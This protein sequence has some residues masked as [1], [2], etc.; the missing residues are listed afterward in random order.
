MWEKVLSKEQR[1]VLKQAA[2]VLTKLEIRKFFAVSLIQVFLGLV[3]LV[4]IG[5]IGILGTLAITGISTN[6]PGDRVRSVLELLSIENS[7][8]QAQ[9]AVIGTIAAILMTFRTLFSIYIVRRVTFFLSRRGAVMSERLVSRLL[10]QEITSLQKRKQQE[11]L[12]GVTTG[13][14]AITMGILNTISILTADLVLLVVLGVGLFALDWVVALLSFSIIGGTAYILYRLLA[15]RSRE[16]GFR[17]AELSVSNNSRIL[18][19]L[20]SYRELVVRDRRG[21][22]SKQISDTRMQMANYGAEKAF[23]PNITKYVLEVVMIYAALIIAASQFLLKD[24]VQAIGMLAIFLA[25]STRMS[26]SLLRVQQSFLVMKGSIGAAMP[27]IEL[28]K[29]IQD[30]EPIG[31]SSR[32]TNFDH[33][34]IN[35]TV[36]V[37][38]LVYGYPDSQRNATEGISLVIEE[39]KYV[40]IVGPSGSGKTTLVDLILGI[41]R[42]SSGNVLI[43]GVPPWDLISTQPGLIAYVPQDV[44][45]IN[46]TVRDNIAMGYNSDQFSDADFEDAIKLSQLTHLIDSLPDG[47]DSVLA[48]KGSN[49]SGGQRQRIG[50]ARALFTKPKILIL[51]EATSSLDSSIE[52]GISDSLHSLRGEIT[53]IVIAHR[54]SSIMK[55]DEIIYIESGKILASGD[56]DQ[57]RKLVP[58]FDMHAR[59]MGIV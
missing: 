14:D 55:A 59:L 38:G 41:L 5:L 39:G 54:L 33:S 44:M 16:I 2:N 1:E 22:Y 47:L 21:Y 10:N 48:D 13:V 32:I 58:D 34:N 57:L 7:T 40:A 20:N 36:E 18:E 26:P 43:G 45:I 50:I 25:A 30:T 49:L 52:A 6:T 3:D 19:V 29:S 12:Y 24:A 56:F 4:A 11:I 17:Q 46:G 27:T 31:E 42:P 15:V 8:L 51:D 35:F 23:M 53:V 9:V 37:F 28:L